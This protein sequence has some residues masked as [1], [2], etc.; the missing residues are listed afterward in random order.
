MVDTVVLTLVDGVRIV[1]P[2]AL[3]L[4]TPY[5]LREQQDY[6]E[7]E[8]PFV[9]RVLQPGEN[10]IDI[11]ANYGVYTLP[12]AQKVGVSGHVWAFEP[13]ASTAQF[14]AQ[15]IEANG[16]GHVTLEQKAVSSA[17]GSA[18]L[19][20]HV[21]SELRSIVHGAVPSGGSEKV[22]LV[23][24]DDCMDRFRWRD[25]DLIKI[26]A[27]GEEVNIVKGGRRF[28]ACLSPLVQYELRKNAA[29]MNFELI[30]DFAAIGYDSYRLL[31]GLN[32][33]V[34]FDAES[35][36]DS[37]LLNLF[38]CNAVGAERLFGRGLLLRSGD[39]VG[40]SKSLSTSTSLGAK[41]HWRH[42]L[43]H[44]AYA[45]PLVS[46]WEV[47]EQAGDSSDVQQALS[48]YARSCDAALTMPERFCA[49]EASFL[50]FR[51]LC[52]RE[53]SHL[54]LASLARV[55]HD[56]GQ[57]A[58][59]VNALTQ[60]LESIRRT[61]TVDPNEPFLAPLERF[62]SIVPG[63]ALGSWLLAAVLEQLEQRERL[64]S[65]YA[66]ARALERLEAIH[67]LGF[68]GPGMERRLELVRLCIDRARSANN[69]RP[70]ATPNP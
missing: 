29:D 67:A 38:C 47:A 9:R 69:R 63:E 68:G 25:I 26:D 50:R 40:G 11:G 24:L 53:P 19:A 39:L 30:R 2:D 46:V 12:M 58:V 61:G 49:L 36:P 31:P 32:L 14:L 15:G 64:S 54:R 16:F 57:R 8:L 3:D 27:E 34:P 51:A 55:A 18:Q 42:A 62:D 48:F 33:L 21:H 56:Y 10:V 65:F 22:S 52:E 13:S 17:P 60:L 7:D 43:A 6:F 20:L 70:T 45:V 44:L 59:A 66:G 5:V 41:Y 23:T 37:Y 1:V 28:F 4:I 35:P